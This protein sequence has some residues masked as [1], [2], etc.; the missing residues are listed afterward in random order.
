[1]N[2]REKLKLITEGGVREMNTVSDA[3]AMVGVGGSDLSADQTKRLALARKILPYVQSLKEKNKEVLSEIYEE[4]KSDFP[5]EDELTLCRMMKK[6]M[7]GGNSYRAQ[8]NF[9]DDH[10]LINPSDLG[11]YESKKPKK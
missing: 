5:D 6:V 4:I 10:G 8:E 1:M 7:N 11:I 3:P 2:I 9:F